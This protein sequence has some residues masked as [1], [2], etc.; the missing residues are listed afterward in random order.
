M[1]GKGIVFSVFNLVVHLS[2]MGQSPDSP[3]N[4]MAG[5]AAITWANENLP[6]D[7]VLSSF[8][9]GGL[10]FFSEHPVVNLDGLANDAT[11]YAYNQRGAIREYVE[12]TGIDY[13][14][15]YK[16]WD[17]GDVVYRVPYTD[18][19]FSTPLYY[20]VIRVDNTR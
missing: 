15:S 17:I 16:Y 9:S 4:Q 1:F 10:G 5:H 13:Y 19:R 6:P 2:V 8:D 12:D 11:L 20:H 18:P 7:A 14:I 3:T